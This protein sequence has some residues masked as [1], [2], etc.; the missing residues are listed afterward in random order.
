MTEVS[1]Y[2]IPAETGRLRAFGLAV[3]VHVLIIGL[4]LLSAHWQS[5]SNPTPI[6]A[7]V[8]DPVATQAAP[9]PVPEVTPEPEPEFV[10]PPK[11][12]EIVPPVID[13]EIAL[14]AEKKRKA[15]DEKRARE[16]REKEEKQARLEKK[17]E[18]DKADLKKRKQEL[19]DKAQ[20]DKARAQDMQRIMAQAGSGGSGDAARTQGA[21]GDASY[22]GMVAAKIKS[23]TNFSVPENMVGNPAVEYTVELL[24]DG[25][26]R[27]PIKKNKPSGVPGF[28]EAVLNAIEKSQ[29]YPTD[30]NGSVPSSISVIH[31]PKDQ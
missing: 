3:L 29:P 9:L 30:K 8:W 11:V 7:E 23:N 27:R 31:K 19:L 12:E 15:E 20:R 1:R 2:T 25:S 6:E 4:L 26:I 18:Q 24:P 21:R 14:K 10:P 22:L 17:K 13:P 16:R 28:D 5:P